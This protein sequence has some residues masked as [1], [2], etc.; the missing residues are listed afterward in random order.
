V[1]LISP[2]PDDEILGAGGFLAAQ[3]RRSVPVTVIAV[4][5]GEAAYPDVENLAGLRRREQE[6][7]LA[8]IGIEANG[9]QRMGLPDGD[10]HTREADL[11]SRIAGFLD[12]T[13]LL[14][15]PWPHDP[16]PDHEACGRAATAAA[17]TT[18]ALHVSYFFWTWHH[19]R[20]D[21]IA[22]LRLSRFDLDEDL[23][24]A[25]S[26]ALAEYGSQLH[27]DSGQ[28]ILPEPLLAPAR[29]SF[30]TFVIHDSRS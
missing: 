5:D 3:A 4:T 14:L 19:C 6:K 27:R 21:T 12:R 25:K 15:A 16:H 30:E 18:G 9:I 10:V 26:L 23:Q 17:R 28:P 2:H 22:S 11:A 24:Q 29:R 7:A 20:P 1:V 13:T 8:R